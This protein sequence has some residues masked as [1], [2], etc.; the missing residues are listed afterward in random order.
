[1]RY[2]G[3]DLGG[4]HIAAAL[5]SQEGEVIHT[6]NQPTFREREAEELF[7]DIVKMCQELIKTFKLDAQSLKGIGIGVPGSVD[8]EKGMIIYANNLKIDGFQAKQYLE[9]SL[10]F[11]VYVA[12]DA[13]CAALGEVIAGGAKGS[14][15]AVVFTLGTGVGGGI[16]INGKIFSGFYPGGA[17][18]GHQIIKHGGRP[19]TCGNRGCLE[20]YASATALILSANQKALANPGSML[21]AMSE[22]EAAQMTAKIPF[23][24]AAR[25]DKVAQEVIESYMEYLAV[26]IAN[27]VNVFNPEIILLGG[28]VAKQGDNLILPLTEKVKTMVYGGHMSTV[29]RTASRGNDA[30]LIGAAMLAL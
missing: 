17:E 13:D 7:Q 28:G 10:G 29:I 8:T 27:A 26:G 4:T 18:L 16:I 24:A 5:V 22:G 20:A 3:V 1:M 30:G 9:E 21:Y 19:C 15:D 25:G 23:D 14:R 11:P 12:N 2:I 6:L